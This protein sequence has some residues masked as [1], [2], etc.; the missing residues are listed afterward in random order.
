MRAILLIARRDLL[1]YLRTMGGYI[2]IAALLFILGLLFNSFGLGGAEKKSADVLAVFFRLAS[3]CT[4]V[5]AVLLSTRLLAEEKQT[6]TI[7]LLYSAPVRDFEI[8]V[9]KF[10]S[11]LAFLGIFLAL[12]TFMPALIFVNGKVSFGH[13][14]SGYLGLFLM[15]AGSLAIGM[16]GSTLASSQVVAV[17]LSAV[18]QV[19]MYACLWLAQV[20]ERPLSDLFAAL[21]Y[22]PHFSQFEVGIVS[23][24]DVIYFLLVVYVALFSATRI[25]EARRW[26]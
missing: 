2:I 26:K 3:A 1:A 24:K 23:S 20:S 10:L 4:V 6:G 18:L 13:I 14:V 21:A 8:V 16:L 19:A 25:L 17:M 7:T 22:F 9:G 12:S 5:A 15:G 11:G